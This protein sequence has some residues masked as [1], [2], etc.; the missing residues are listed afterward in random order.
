MELFFLSSIHHQFFSINEA[1]Y[2]YPSLK[3]TW[4]FEKLLDLLESLNF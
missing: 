2:F 3:K 1:Q 4:G